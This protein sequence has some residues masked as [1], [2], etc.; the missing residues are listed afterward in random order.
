MTILDAHLL[1]SLFFFYAKKEGL[2]K[3]Y[4]KGYFVHIH[5]V[6]EVQQQ[7]LKYIN[8]IARPMILAKEDPPPT[9]THANIDYTVIPISFII[10]FYAITSALFNVCTVK[11]TPRYTLTYIHTY[12]HTYHSRFIP[13][14]IAEVFLRDTYVLP[15]LVSYEEHCRRD[16]W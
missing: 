12:I 14:G 6:E 13:E 4:I 10:W 7:V 11:S 16:R 5:S 1:C 9:W 8:V 2:N 3:C 15:K